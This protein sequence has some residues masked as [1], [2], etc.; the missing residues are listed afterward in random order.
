MRTDS[1]EVDGGRHGKLCFSQ[2]ESGKVWM[3]NIERIRNEESNW[4]CNVE[5]DG[6]ESPVVCLCREVVLHVLN[7]IKTGRA[8]DLQTYHRS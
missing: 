4:D 6:V 2:D 7:E 5:G 3:A 8:L 1:I